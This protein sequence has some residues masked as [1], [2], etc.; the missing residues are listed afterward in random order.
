MRVNVQGHAVLSDAAIHA[1]DVRGVHVFA[2]DALIP[3]GMYVLL[4][5]GH[6]TPRF[7]KTRDGALLYYAF[8]NRD[9]S[10]WEN[11]PGPVHVL[12]KQHTYVERGPSLLLR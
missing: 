2:D 3:P 5:S 12:A 11:C 8:M 6:G 9:H 4:T 1:A 7:A 10:I